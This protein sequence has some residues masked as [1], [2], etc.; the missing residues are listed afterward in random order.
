MA[1]DHMSRDFE[2]LA[3]RNLPRLPSIRRVPVRISTDGLIL[4]G[5]HPSSTSVGSAMAPSA[6]EEASNQ[7]EGTVVQM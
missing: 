7:S 2:G 5:G 4:L 1:P 3:G 6:R